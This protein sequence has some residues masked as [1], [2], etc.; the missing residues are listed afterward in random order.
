M[1]PFCFQVSVDTDDVTGEVLAVYFHIRKGRVHTTHE[2]AN[3]DVFADYDRKGQLLGI[4]LL[5]PCK[6]SI[7]DQL[8]TDEPAD[9][10][11]RTKEFMRNAGPRTMIA[12]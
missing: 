2:F 11:K 12:A 9:L 10:R 1:K 6:V 4:E 8:A 5:A 7:V 3:G